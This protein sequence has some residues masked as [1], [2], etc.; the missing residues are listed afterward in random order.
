[1]KKNV[2]IFL[3]HIEATFGDEYQIKRINS[4]DDGS[5]I[6][7]F[8]YND[9]PEKGMMTFIT[10]GLSEADHS[11]WVGGKPELILSLE[12][13]DPS[14]GFAIAHL[15]AERRGIKR[16]SFGDLFIFDEPV[17]EESDM[18]GF[19]AFAPSIIDNVTS[20][21][22]TTDKPIFL[23]GMYPIYREEIELYN[24]VGLQEFWFTEG[25]DLYNVKRKNLAFK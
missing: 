23:T 19:F 20:R 4:I 21:I 2:E 5:P 15:V 8:I 12:T 16:F 9:L 17:S 24:E 22:E 3:E 25:F 6:N 14:W 13:N 10:Y 11:E 7:L 18:V 1:M